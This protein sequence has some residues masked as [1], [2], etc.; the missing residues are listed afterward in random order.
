MSE[1]ILGYVMFGDV[2][3]SLRPSWTM[4][5]THYCESNNESRSLP[6]VT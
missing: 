5:R 4:G 1:V 2:M 3:M 6:A